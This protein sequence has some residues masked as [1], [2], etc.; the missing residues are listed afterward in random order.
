[1]TNKCNIFKIYNS[2]KPHQ[3]DPKDVNNKPLLNL[4][5]IEIIELNNK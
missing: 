4:E 1:M 3:K 5:F 2:N